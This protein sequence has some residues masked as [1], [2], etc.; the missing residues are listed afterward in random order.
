MVT[1]EECEHSLKEICYAYE[2]RDKTPFG[3]PIGDTLDCYK[4]G[5]FDYIF[6]CDASCQVFV[7][8]VENKTSWLP[9]APATFTSY[10]CVEDGSF[11]S[12]AWVCDHVLDCAAGEDEEEGE[13][14]HTHEENVYENVTSN[15]LDNA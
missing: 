8:C 6:E 10:K 1:V 12:S 5:K 2:Y 4:N 9:V 13:C 11:V 14:Q 15:I 7:M 3:V